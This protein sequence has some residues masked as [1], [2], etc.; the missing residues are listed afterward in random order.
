VENFP[1]LSEG[2]SR[3]LAA[4]KIGVN[5]EKKEVIICSGLVLGNGHHF[6]EDFSIEEDFT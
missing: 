3:D 6:M 2:K 1:S 4:E 5:G